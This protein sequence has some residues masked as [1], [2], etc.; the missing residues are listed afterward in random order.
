M[1]EAQKSVLE[2]SFNRAVKIHGCDERI[3]SDAGLL[4]LREA[5]HRPGLTEWLAARLSDPRRQDLIRYQLVELLPA[6][7]PVCPGA[8]LL[9]ARTPTAWPTIRP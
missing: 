7:T 6:G 9:D 3:T 2:P 5:D 1:S 8:G 4:L